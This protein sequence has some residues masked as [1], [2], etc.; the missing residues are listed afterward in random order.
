MK[1]HVCAAIIAAVASASIPASA[2]TVDQLVSNT[3]LLNAELDRCK[4]LGMASVDDARC[5]TAR[6]AEDKRFFGNGT[7]YTPGPVQVFQHP[8][9]IVPQPERQKPPEETAGPPHG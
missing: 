2:Q 9:H 6:A 8:P 3:K 1:S 5:K 7:T 4:Q